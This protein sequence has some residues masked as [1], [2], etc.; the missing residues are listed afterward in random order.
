[1]IRSEWCLFG[2][3]W[4]FAFTAGRQVRPWPEKLHPLRNDLGAI[5]FASVVARFIFA[6]P[7]PAFQVDLPP[8]A[9]I[10]VAGT[11]HL[12]GRY[13]LGPADAPLALPPPSLQ[14]FL[15]AH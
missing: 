6:R 12:A 4:L 3:C 5:T 1:M 10:L 9:Q 13:A 11:S 8:L 15:S 2:R 7:Q 14:T